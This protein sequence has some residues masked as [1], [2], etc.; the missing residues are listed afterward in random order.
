MKKTKRK[1]T[2]PFKAQVALAA[3]KENETLATLAELLSVSSNTTKMKTLSKFGY[4][5]NPLIKRLSKSTKTR[6]LKTVC[7]CK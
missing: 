7:Y 1:F 5:L 4:G 3:V 6:F 2:A